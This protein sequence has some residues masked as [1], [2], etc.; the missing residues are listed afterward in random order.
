MKN[1]YTYKIVCLLALFAGS[2]HA[3]GF[4]CELPAIA[5]A[6]NDKL[7]YG[8]LKQ[9]PN[10][11]GTSTTKKSEK[12]IK[13]SHEHINL[14]EKYVTKENKNEYFFSK[15]ELKQAVDNLICESGM[16]RD[17]FFDYEFDRHENHRLRVKGLKYDTLEDE[18]NNCEDECAELD[19][20]V[21]FYQMTTMVLGSAVVLAGYC[22]YS[23]RG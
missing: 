10:A 13:F 21:G 2:I 17:A 11:R 9:A 15:S 18:L 3:S 8:I 7:R 14:F 20:L 19:N 5:P 23:S 12:K 4:N 1:L 22:I 6:K 16:T